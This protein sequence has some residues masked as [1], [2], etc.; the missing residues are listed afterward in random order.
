MARAGLFHGASTPAISRDDLIS[1][2]NPHHQPPELA[3]DRTALG[4]RQEVVL[5]G[6]ALAGPVVALTTALIEADPKRAAA[7]LEPYRA[8]LRPRFEPYVTA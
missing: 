5:A 6:L 3:R 7:L 2:D 8:R 4:L 1:A